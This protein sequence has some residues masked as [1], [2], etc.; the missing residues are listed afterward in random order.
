MSTKNEERRLREMLSFYYKFH[1]GVSLHFRAT[2]GRYCFINHLL[3]PTYLIGSLTETRKS[4]EWSRPLKWVRFTLCFSP[5]VWPIECYSEMEY[6]D[7]ILT[8]FLTPWVTRDTAT[9]IC[10][11]GPISEQSWI[12]SLLN[13]N[14]PELVSWI[15]IKNFQ[16]FLEMKI[17]IN[18]V[19]TLG[20][21]HWVS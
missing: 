8:I 11:M 19:L 21:V 12:I 18:R 14:W 6:P 1:S 3:G 15:F 9:F 4:E 20:Q 2:N 5:L 16:T 10:T 17:D 7:N 13:P